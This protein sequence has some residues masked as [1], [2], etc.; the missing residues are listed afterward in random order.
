MNKS[1]TDKCRV[2]F[3]V[4]YLG[5]S[6]AEICALRL[7]EKLDTNRFDAKILHYYPAE[8]GIES[9][10]DSISDRFVF[11]DRKSSRTFFIWIRSMLYEMKQFRPDVIVSFGFD[12]SFYGRLIGSLAGTKHFVNVI[13]NARVPTGFRGFIYR[14]VEKL[15]RGLQ[16]IQIGVSYAVADILKDCFHIPS[17]KVRA[18][19]NGIE[20]EDFMPRFAAPAVRSEFGIREGAHVVTCVASLN[21]Y[22]N[23]PFLLR[24][25]RLVINEEPSCIFLLVGQDANDYQQNNSGIESK[26]NKAYLQKLVGELDIGDNVIFAGPRGDIPEILSITD[27]FAM[28]SWQEGLNVAVIE[29]MACELPVVV[30]SVG[31]LREVVEDGIVG[32]LVESNNAEQMSDRILE[33]LRNP[34]R[35]VKFGRAGRQRAEKLFTIEQMVQNYQNTILEVWR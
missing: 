12:C 35:C 5:F 26:S 31:G 20:I 34:Q 22:K 23:H 19:Y 27:V 28:P 11:I 10:F 32:Y 30:S 13:G 4:Q 21:R 7:F 29:A 8:A 1:K 16:Q 25:A 17:S 24:A 18:I 6:G 9:K 33:L 15:F 2:L 14:S 3:L